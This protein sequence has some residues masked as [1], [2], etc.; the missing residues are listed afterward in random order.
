[1]V[2]CGKPFPVCVV[3]FSFSGTAV[4]GVQLQTTGGEYLSIVREGFRAF[5]DKWK[6]FCFTFRKMYHFKVKDA[7]NMKKQFIF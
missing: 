4:T 3:F 7:S 1:M 5:H 2:L 6:L